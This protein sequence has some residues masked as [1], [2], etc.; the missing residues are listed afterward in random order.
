V[1]ESGLKVFLDALLIFQA[2]MPPG[3][4]VGSLKKPPLPG[5]FFS[6]GSQDNFQFARAQT[7]P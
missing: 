2:L 4:T 3:S 7:I 5:G 1:D 6:R